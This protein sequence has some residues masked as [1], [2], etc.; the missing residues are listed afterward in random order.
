MIRLAAPHVDAADI[1]AVSDVLRSGHLVQGRQVAA[2]EAEL[3]SAVGSAHSVAVNSCTS[4]LH[5]ALLAL[6]VTQGDEV[7]V[8]AFSWP[9]TANVV[10]FCGAVPV[11]V[12]IEEKSFGMDPVALNAVLRRHPSV[13]AIVPVHPFGEMAD[14]PKILAESEPRGISIIEDAAC[15]LGSILDSRPAGRWGIMGCYSFHPR[16]AITTGEGGV[17][18]TDDA[19]LARRLRML[20]NHGLDPE[21]ATP[22]FVLAG[23]NLRMTDLQAALGRTQLRKLDM[24]IAS[25]RTQAAKYTSL[26]A[27]SSVT[28]P[29]ARSASTH[30][31]QSF[32][33]LVPADRASER[34]AIIARMRADG[35]EAS[36]GTHHIPLT[37]FYRSRFGYAPGDFPVADAVARRSIALPL[38]PLL[39]ADDQNR[40]VA[41]LREHAG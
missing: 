8:P 35:V 20:R 36:I 40:V 10:A 3:S 21:A 12:D 23:L 22:D 24:L 4:A 5:L 33:V 31:F 18:V 19:I 25:R 37:T 30:V 38:H 34:D 15:A 2:F 11:F 26:L 41:V 27:G 28:V 29:I 7:L 1:E 39:T 32:V 17:I 16:K 9:A 6:G 14:V 13:K